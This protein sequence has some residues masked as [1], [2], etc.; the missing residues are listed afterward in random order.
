MDKNKEWNDI[1]IK[2]YGQPKNGEL[3]KVFSPEIMG[4]HFKGKYLKFT[5]NFTTKSLQS[6]VTMNVIGT[7]STIK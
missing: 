5:I 2:Y 3:H 6:D 7:T 4:L 1:I